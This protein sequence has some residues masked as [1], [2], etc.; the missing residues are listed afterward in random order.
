M[1]LRNNEMEKLYAESIHQIEEGSI[2]R[3]R[4]L[5]VKQDG[6][7]VD[8]GY[9]SEGFIPADEFSAEELSRT[10]AGDTVEAYVLDIQ[11]SE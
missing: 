7:I 8:I 10:K 5:Y 1:E 4:V 11:D 9:K 3:G 6:V 2:L